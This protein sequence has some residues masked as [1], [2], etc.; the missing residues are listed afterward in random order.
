MVERQTLNTGHGGQTDIKTLNTGHGRQ[1]DIKHWVWWT[2]RCQTLGI[3]DRQMLNTGHGEGTDAKHLAW[4][5]V[6]EKHDVSQTTCVNA[7]KIRPLI[8][9]SVLSHRVSALRR[10]LA[11]RHTSPPPPPHQP[12]PPTTNDPISLITIVSASVPVTLSATLS[13]VYSFCSCDTVS[14]TESRS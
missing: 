7:N 2:D 1:M 5:A 6:E 8:R 10:Y 3:V 14:N 12:A 13:H 9:S 11:P 4:W